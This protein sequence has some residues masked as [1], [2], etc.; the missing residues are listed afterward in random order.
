MHAKGDMEFDINKKIH[1][2]VTW[3]NFANHKNSIHQCPGKLFEKIAESS[4]K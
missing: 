2:F 1:C 3:S 4:R